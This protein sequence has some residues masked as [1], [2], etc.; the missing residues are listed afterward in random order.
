MPPAVPHG[1]LMYPPFHTIDAALARSDSDLVAAAL[2]D[3][4][5]AHDRI[6]IISAEEVK[7]LGEPLDDAE[8]RRLL[9]RLRV[10]AGEDLD[11]LDQT[12]RVLIHGLALVQLRL[13]GDEEQ[14]RLHA[15]LRPPD[16]QVMN[17]FG[18]WTTAPI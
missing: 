4:G 10:R 6:E 14:V 5:F 12:R 1:R 13:H 17:Y 11:E 18:R 7:G 15:M 8:V 16:G 3:A 2:A 9:I